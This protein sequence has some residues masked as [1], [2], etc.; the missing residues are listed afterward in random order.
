MA[1]EYGIR[2]WEME[3]LRAEEFIALWEDIRALEKA[4]KSNG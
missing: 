3:D 4:M 2:P 1:R